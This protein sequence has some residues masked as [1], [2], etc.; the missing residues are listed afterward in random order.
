MSAEE[1]SQFPR[2]IVLIG[3]SGVGKTTVG[4]MIAERLGWPFVDTDDVIT[5]RHGRTPADI[6]ESD[7]ELAFREIEA[8]VVA[9]AAKQSPAVISTGGGA[10]LNPRSRRA[11]GERGLIC[12]LDATP[13][14][15]ARRIDDD[16][17]DVKRPLLGED[18]E[19]RLHELDRER[20]P[21][22]NNADLWVPV[23]GL[24][25]PHGEGPKVA[26]Q[27]A[28]EAAA[29]RILHSWATEGA[30][31]V[32]QPRRLDRFAA[33]EPPRVP[34]A[35]V[36]TGAER[37]PVWVGPGEIGRLPDRLRQLELDNRR[38][39]VIS[40]ANV[41]EHHGRGVA[42]TLDSA[43]IAG[44]SYIVPSGEAS[45]TLRVAGEV[46]RWLAEQRAERR[47][48]IVGL[49]GGVVGDLAGFVAATY[50]RG[51][52]LIQIPTSLLAMND[53]AIGGKSAVDLPA[54]KN[55]VGAFRQPA[56]VLSDVE[57]LRTLPR[58]SYT[59]GWAEVL[60]HALILDPALL[61]L[62]EREAGALTTSQ[63][64]LD[65]VAGVVARSSRLK[66]LIVS[67]DPTERGLR[68]IL[69]YGHTIGHGIETATGYEQY[70]HGE[71]VAVGMM[72][73]AQIG[74][75]LG[76]MERELLARQAD[77]LRAFDL[78]L[79]APGVRGR[80]VLEAM[81]LD[82]K[83]AQ[84]RRSFVLLGGAGRAVVRN[85]VPDDVVQRAVAD[86]VRE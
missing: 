50:L 29:A 78:P 12:Y 8:A 14:E 51:M 64:D 40:D 11:L 27:A 30:R 38:I 2:Q 42:E 71:A 46:Y 54:G 33:V 57:T 85:D 39:F 25:A 7:G 80:A 61:S 66:A 3:L 47:D 83:V 28:G 52:P 32:A 34:A 60:K 35:V 84:G 18:I 58:R 44:A 19:A 72:G 82:K 55:L 49:G 74:A 5:S 56:A 43:G 45:K 10:F 24:S 73:A 31:L 79:R 69:N 4:R 62:L 37:Y 68:A 59:E 20:R 36:D 13:A 70:L 77:L 23:Q 86:L 75:E 48:L 76:T 63:P 53:A 21:F 6:L 15:I 65:L 67:S 17:P 9:E 16:D 22:Y 26:A 41:M 81:R 1:R